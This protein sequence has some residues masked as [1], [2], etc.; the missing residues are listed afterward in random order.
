MDSEK[1]DTE[2]LGALHGYPSV[3]TRVEVCDG[4]D[5]HGDRGYVFDVANGV[6]LIELDAGCIWPVSESWEVVE[7]I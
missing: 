3:G 4:S 5:A 7:V 6:C 1:Q 2:N